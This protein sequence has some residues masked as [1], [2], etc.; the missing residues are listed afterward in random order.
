M[1]LR[2]PLSELCLLLAVTSVLFLTDALAQQT[3]EPAPAAAAATS[4]PKIDTGDTA[5]MLTS[6]ALVLLMTPGLALFYG[7]MVRR[8]NVL[9]TMM[10]SFILV[11]L[12]SVLWALYGY[13]L[14]FHEGG[15]WGGF[16]W[17]FLNGVGADPDPYGYAATIPH[18][19]YMVFQLMFAI[20]TPALITGAFAERMK[21]SAMLL[22]MTLWATFVYN[23]LAHW[24]WGKG[25]WLRYGD[26]GAVFGALDFAGGTVVH[27]SSGVSALIVALV[28][29]KRI[30]FGSEPIIP[31]NLTMTLTGTGLLW[32]GWFG[33]NAGSAVS[34]GGLTASAF[35]VTHFAAAAATLSWAFAEWIF[36][37]K[38]SALGAVSGAVA[39]LVGIT[40]A[41]GY[42]SPMPA[43][44]IGAVAG[45]V[46]FLATSYVKN[47]FGYDD[48]LDA[49][50]IHAV[51]GTAGAFLTGVFASTAVNAAAADGL[52]RGNPKQLV[53]QT[54]AVVATWVF[55]AVMSLII[56]KVVDVLVGLRVTADDEILGLDSTQHGESG[57]NLEA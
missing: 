1:S 26:P 11:A 38:P 19:V 37:G 25:G 42:V 32:F 43:L 40:P 10:Q 17:S 48:S 4:P 44:I 21:F 2:K 47:K 24:V 13:S 15:F 46:C 28:V 56:I 49:F 50:G 39:G 3:G 14:A 52:L 23:P 35:V 12:V 41:S 8:K 53:N 33:F 7:G 6:A 27:I 55:A 22:F 9:G 51:G 29:G 45:L 54:V 34:S 16:D 18:Q 57:Y 36:K 31:H 5:W 20:I 30:G